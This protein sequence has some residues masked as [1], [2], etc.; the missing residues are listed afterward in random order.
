MA[1]RRKYCALD[2]A[3]KNLHYQAKVP[4]NRKLTI[5][6]A[7]ES[8]L[9]LQKNIHIYDITEGEGYFV[10]HT[11]ICGFENHLFLLLVDGHFHAITK[12]HTVLRQFVGNKNKEFLQAV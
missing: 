11:P 9:V 1:M 10:H 4:Y 5:Q 7:N 3:A 8:A 6:D 12:I 2:T